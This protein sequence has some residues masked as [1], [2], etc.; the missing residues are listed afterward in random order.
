MSIGQEVIMSKSRYA[1]LVLTLCLLGT[2]I[3]ATAQ[4]GQDHEAKWQQQAQDA[5]KHAR[6]AENAGERGSTEGMMKHAEMALNKAKEAQ[7]AGHNALLNEAVYTLGEAIEH[8]R[9]GDVKDAREHVMQAIMKLSQATGTQLPPGSHAG[10]VNESEQGGTP[11]EIR[12]QVQAAIK[13]AR[14]AEDAGEQSNA[15]VLVNHAQ[16]ALNKAK[17]AQKA[18]HNARLNEAVYALGEAIEHG[19]KGDVK[20]AREHMMHAIMRLSE[21]AG[22]QA[23]QQD[24][25]ASKQH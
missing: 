7:K 2:A 25:G 19:R 8:G 20:D 16:M 14:A 23:P 5:I 17:E 24:S 18:G 9:K 22:L 6:E 3:S 1:S 15:Q 12:P 21:A 11:K 13:H 10:A 4:T